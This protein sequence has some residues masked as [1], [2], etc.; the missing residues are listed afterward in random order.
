MKVI[1]LEEVKGL[2]KKGDVVNASD[3]YARNFLFPKN[4]AKEATTGNIKTL[5]EQKKSQQLKKDK[6]LEDAKALADKLEKITVELKAK[7]GEG[8]RL[9]GSVTA[10]EIAEALEKQHKIKFDKR[11]LVLPEPIRELGVRNVEVKVYPS[12]VGSLKVHVIQV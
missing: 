7:A 6:E 4:L 5:G 8:G 9:F 2:G 3:G 11:K 10:K 1:L 12:V